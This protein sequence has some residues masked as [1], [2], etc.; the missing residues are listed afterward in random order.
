MQVLIVNVFGL[1]LNSPGMLTAVETYTLGALKTHWRF[2]KIPEFIITKAISEKSLGFNNQLSSSDLTAE[3]NLTK[4]QTLI[5]VAIR[6]VL[7]ERVLLVS[8]VL[9]HIS[10]FCYGSVQWCAGENRN[11]FMKA[12]ISIIKNYLF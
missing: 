12:K 11:S 4:L 3:L 9:F 8:P 2:I 10:Y 1:A 6:C 7:V 5:S